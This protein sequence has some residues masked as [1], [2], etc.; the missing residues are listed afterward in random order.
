MQP[1]QNKTRFIFALPA[2]LLCTFIFAGDLHA[3]L[4]TVDDDG[5]AQFITIQ[6]AID[7]AAI[8]GDQISIAP[9]TYYETINFNGKAIHLYSTDGP[10]LTTIDAGGAF[11]AVQCV[12]GETSQ[13]ILEGFTVTGGAANGWSSPDSTGGAMLNIGTSPTVINCIFTA[14][15][16]MQGGAV[17]NEHPAEPTIISCTFTRNSATF[18]AAMSN[19]FCDPII[20]DCLFTDNE[21]FAGGALHNQFN[22]EPPITNCTFTRNTAAFFGGAIN[23]EFG[24][25]PHLTNCLFTAN[26]ANEGA[27]IYNSFSRPILDN[28]IL[29]ANDA[30][31]GAAISDQLSS[32]SEITNC[33]LWANSPG[34]IASF[35]S[36][37]TVNYSCVQNG[38]SGNH[39]I[40]NDP[41]FVQP[42][43]YD[44]N[45]LWIEGDY[46]LLATSPCIDAG[47]NT[48]VPIDSL[49]IAG[50]PRITDGNLD[51]TSTV[52]IGAHEYQVPP[53][54][55]P[56]KLTPRVLNPDSKGKWIKAHFIL[57]EGFDVNDVAPNTPAVLQPCGFESDHIDAFLNDANL[58]AIDIA[59]D[60]KDFANIELPAGPIEVTVTASFNN[61]RTY[62]G[63]DIITL[64]PNKF[65]NIL[66]FTS[67][68]LTSDCTAPDWC[69]GLDLNHDS[70][71][72]F[73]DIQ[74]Y[75]SR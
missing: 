7:N 58:V 25:K 1:T 51:G 37:T 8:T 60:R 74:T 31:T 63:I 70:L 41:C 62:R 46:Y 72:N 11:H 56:M 69:N 45:G 14:N 64:K 54:D 13:T 28:C 34:Q 40:D 33:I 50:R 5:P 61:G 21:A 16:A 36:F 68:W 55:V 39:N 49:D 35:T 10:E 4:F 3:D 6:Q 43:Y 67:A 19:S 38:Y 42:G 9:G 23:N 20:I 2:V 29:A 26:T 30:Q 32:S 17:Y 73:K 52:D 27:A 65:Q 24:G 75:L 22:S 57:P 59:F 48:V 47:T 12:T 18:G 53:F 44:P 66:R 15:S 71:I